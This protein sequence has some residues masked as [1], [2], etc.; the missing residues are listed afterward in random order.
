M[1]L[2]RAS[3]DELATHVF[4]L[5]KWNSGKIRTLDLS[6]MIGDKQEVRTLITPL[7]VMGKI[8]SRR[9]LGLNGATYYHHDPGSPSFEGHR[10]V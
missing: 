8:V 5:I 4:S 2:A 10:S 6:R 3:G 1:A 7:T 9:G